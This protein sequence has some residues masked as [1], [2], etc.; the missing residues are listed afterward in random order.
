VPTEHGGLALGDSAR[1]I[2][3]GETAVEIV[4][5]PKSERR[6][7]QRGGGGGA[8]PVDD[9]LFDALRGLRRELAQQH[10]VPPYVIFHDAT[11]RE[12]ASMRPSS[13]TELGGIS[14]I[15]SRKLDAYGDAFLGVIRQF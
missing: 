14:G 8:N 15:G 7:K 11:L 6:R 4:M 1:A 3:K 12:M 5:P 9:P 10:G 13:L 2:L